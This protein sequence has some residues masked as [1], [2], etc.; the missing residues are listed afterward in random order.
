MKKAATALLALTLF[1]PFGVTAQATPGDFAQ[2]IEVDVAGSPAEF[3]RHFTMFRDWAVGEGSSWTWVAFEI[4]MG[5]RSG[6]YVFGTFNHQMA[7]WDT[8]DLDP[9][10]VREQQWRHVAPYVESFRA[11]LIRNRRELGTAAADAPLRPLYQVV[12]FAVHSGREEAFMQ[13]LGALK[14][15]FESSGAPAE[16]SVF[17]GMVGSVGSEW[18]ISI[19]Y[20]DFASMA[21]ADDD[22]FETLLEGVYGEFHADA[23]QD[24]FNEAV[25]SVKSELLV[26]RPDLSANLPAM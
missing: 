22:A 6:Q 25:A 16:Y 7:D 24:L 8:P 5:E 9:A 1:L 10:A 19:P 26:L 11:Q 17:Q 14:N 12:T 2:V 3:E 13:F 18:V 4:A 15:A 21:P 23:M 20:A